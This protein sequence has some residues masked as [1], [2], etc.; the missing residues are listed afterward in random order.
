MRF[1]A[2]CEADQFLTIFELIR[3]GFGVSMVPD[4]ARSL[5]QGCRPAGETLCVESDGGVY[6]IS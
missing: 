1:V 2:Q 6:R 4:M 3:G 5:G